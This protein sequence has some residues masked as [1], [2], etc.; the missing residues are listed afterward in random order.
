[1]WQYIKRYAHF[2]IIAAL[3][4]GGEVLMDLIQLI[5]HVFNI[6]LI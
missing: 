1:M 3:F 6:Y 2:A 4:M 5:K